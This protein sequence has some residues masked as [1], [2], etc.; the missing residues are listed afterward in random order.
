MKNN[1]IKKCNNEKYF[2]TVLLLITVLALFLML[3]SGSYTG[4][5]NDEF[6]TI[7]SLHLYDMSMIE[8]LESTVSA[9]GLSTNFFMI[10][11]RVW[12]EIGPR[13]DI[14]LMILTALMVAVA[15]YFVG[16][17]GRL[18][19][20]G[21]AGIVSAVLFGFS[22]YVFEVSHEFRFYPWLVLITILSLYFFC[23]LT[24]SR[25]VKVRYI[26]LFGLA[27]GLAV[28]GQI[29]AGFLPIWFFIVDIVLVVLHKKQKKSLFSYV[30][31]APF[32]VILFS[33]YMIRYAT[34]DQDVYLFK[35]M[36]PSVTNLI[37]MPKFMIGDSAPLLVLLYLSIAL[38]LLFV[39]GKA[40]KKQYFALM[41][42]KITLPD[43]RKQ[44]LFALIAISPWVCVLMN[45][46]MI[47]A[48]GETA[49]MFAPRYFQ[50]LYPLVYLSIGITVTYIITSILKVKRGIVFALAIA[51]VLYFAS[52]TY[53]AS[54]TNPMYPGVKY[55]VEW[56]LD[57]QEEIGSD[58]TVLAPLYSAAQAQV[59]Y[60]FYFNGKVLA[61]TVEV[62]NSLGREDI[63]DINT[64][65]VA[66]FSS[67]RTIALETLLAE[68]YKKD[69]LSGSGITIW[70]RVD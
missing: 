10:I 70:R 45:F 21:M 54:L 37:Q 30:I 27:M 50:Y 65:T 12:I 55:G 38:A 15:V 69:E 61:G 48:T 35:I 24:I 28:N 68:K 51:L 7:A 33:H 18:I 58:V 3:R 57:Q 47:K 59:M 42:E 8:W 22:Y 56:I 9:N 53:V 4:L 13:N 26:I 29:L 25:D 32:G 16:L 36:D 14:W 43:Q 2:Y 60:D 6:S 39:L 46:I 31:A 49:N 17:V 1:I 19:Y 62:K 20:G 64:E 5:W 52:Q 23:K 40:Y 34:D 63:N 67:D 41:A 44:F 66:L 11:A